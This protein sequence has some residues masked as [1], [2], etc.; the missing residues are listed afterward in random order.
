[1]DEQTSLTSVADLPELTVAGPFLDGLA[2]QDFAR[3]GEALAP[4]VDL[5][6]LLPGGLREWT[7]AEAVAHR[8]ATWFG[9][10]V[11]FELVESTVGKVANRAHLAWRCRLQAHRL[12]PGWFV[13]EQ[14]AYADADER[15]RIARLDLLCTGY[16]PERS[17]G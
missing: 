5:R 9:D 12:G 1:M 10:T 4:E 15:G 8:F 6:A 17:D 16:L 11:Q 14:L 13:V 2:T 3:V 7:G